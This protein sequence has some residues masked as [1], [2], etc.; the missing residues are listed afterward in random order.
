MKIPEDITPSEIGGQ[1][2]A[3]IKQDGWAYLVARHAEAIE[4]TQ[5]K[6]N[7][8][9]TPPAETQEHKRALQAL[10]NASPDMLVRDILNTA[11]NA[12]KRQQL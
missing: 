12:N 4:A 2:A 11:R 7:D 9:D 3:L 1:V 6:V 5:A 8:L 10:K